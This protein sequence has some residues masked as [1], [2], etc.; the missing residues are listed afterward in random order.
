MTETQSPVAV[1]SR[2]D[3]SF[4][5]VPLLAE[6]LSLPRQGV[7]AV[8]KL[9]AEGATVPFIARY[10]KEATG[11]LDEVQI[12]AIEERRAY[13]IELEERRATV[14]TEI[15]KQGKLTDALA[16]KIRACHTKAELEDLYLPFKP[17]RRTRAIIAK[18][19][20][21]EPLADRMWSQPGD[22][23][24]E[25]EAR[26]FVS[27]EKEVPDAAAALAG[28]RDICAERIAEHADVRKL[29]RE[30][31][32]KEGVIKVQKNEEH[33]AKQT[34]FDMYGSFEEPVANIPSHRYLAIRRGEAEGVLRASIELAPEPLVPPIHAAVGLKPKSPWAGELT[35]A[36][37][38]AVKRLLLPAV[39]SDVRVDLKMQAD[40]AAVEVFAQNLRE[41][42][43]AA[44]FGTKA[45]L[46][47]DPGQRTG[48]KCAVV[49][50][51]GKLLEHTTIYLVGSGD[52]LERAR[53]DLRRICRKYPLRAVAVGNGTH[54]RETEA[55]VK[56]VLASEGLTELFCVPV[57]EAGASVYSASDVAREEFPELDLT[58]RGAIS[59][60]RRLQDPLAELVKVDPKS[61][62]VGQYQHDVY[63]GLLA[64]KLD[65]VVESCVN[66]VGVELN[67]AS[68]PLLARVAGIG[69]SL[70]KKIVAH[71]DL[72]GAFKS[73]KAL[74]DVPGVGPRTFEQAAGFVRVRGGEHPLDASA[75]HP[76]RYGLVE[77]IAADLG[78]PV[79]SLIGDTAA[80][81]R[82]DPKKYEAGDVGSFT[83]NDILSELKKPGRDPR[84]TF[85]P[86]K[87][88]DDVRTMEDLKP[89]MELEGVVTNVTAFGAFVDIGVHQ[90]GL[91]HVSQLADRFVKDPNEVA[92][93]GDK[94]KVRVLEVDL[95]R[96]RISLT[97]KKGG[98]PAGARPQAGG[99]SAGGDARGRNDRGDGRRPAQGQGQ[100]QGQQGK[101]QGSSSGGFRNNPF[102]DLL[103]K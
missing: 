20:G 56:D 33:A 30:A 52:S 103:R 8:A 24:P 58:V 60:A 49:D 102:A 50:E 87:F 35:K 74:L 94:I 89:G 36:A 85:E 37:D 71:R 53:Q 44:P 11:G 101:G 48:C 64:R 16:S 38:D 81:A 70:A 29:V 82:I 98:A 57:S 2:A 28:A 42:L 27:A 79:G 55:F 14:L 5:P 23:S 18:E 19:R 88:R 51:T 22:G 67:T 97:A 100:G 93:V 59:I 63:Q 73:R 45:V 41:L 65:E 31:Y 12:R 4:D 15:Q 43:L 7:S 92:K 83:L 84:A 54:G 13:L 26:A 34:K 61:I 47:I 3:S 72:N 32:A 76:E 40:R 25:E 62:G 68:A 91:V 21:L 6:E 17:K 1:P 9:L 86:P 75:V 78:V 10:R 99:P 96:K 80:I 90:D 95:V 69:P 66:R 39:Q 46:G 77:R